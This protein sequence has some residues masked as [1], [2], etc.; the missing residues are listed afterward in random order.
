VTRARPWNRHPPARGT[1]PAGGGPA[2]SGR[3]R[4]SPGRP[5]LPDHI[6]PG[7]RV[8]FVGINPGLRSAAVGHHFA[9]HSN[10]FWRLMH[11]SGLLPESLNHEDD[12]RLPEFG[13]GITN[14]VRRAT[15]GIDA[16][17]AGD[18]ARG[19]RA[20]VARIRAHRPMVVALVGVT[21]YRA[22]FPSA[23]PRRDRASARSG[24]RRRDAPTRG[25]VLGLRRETLAGSR[26]FVLPNPSGRNATLS[27]DAMLGA[28]RALNKYLYAVCPR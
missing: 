27:Y 2:D 22:L 26:V 10:R 8:L 13:Y 1:A 19:R 24:A 25:G 21:L 18:Y 7:A 3:S 5:G 28:F 4:S 15:P 6:R 9:G 14:L 17:R 23:V 20:L 16:L 11:D 12:A